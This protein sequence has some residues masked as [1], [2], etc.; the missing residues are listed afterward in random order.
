MYGKKTYNYFVVR[1]KSVHLYST[2]TKT[3]KGMNTSIEMARFDT[4][5]SVEEKKLFEK[6]AEIGGFRSLTDFVLKSLR[7]RAEEIIKE[8]ESILASE[9]DN[10]IFFDTILNP[11]KPNAKLI[12]A[13]KK[14]KKASN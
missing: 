2:E 3:M 13:A 11:P 6:A 9:R 8:Y 14:Y 12:A 10:E 1:K 4:R 7:K 5:L